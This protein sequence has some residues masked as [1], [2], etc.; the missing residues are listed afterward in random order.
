MVGFTVGD[1][2]SSPFLR[3]TSLLSRTS[4]PF[5]RTTATVLRE[6]G[7][8]RTGGRRLNLGG[9]GAG[10]VPSSS[11]GPES[12]QVLLLSLI[13]KCIFLCAILNDECKR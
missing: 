2:M 13:Y 1:V 4:S 3:T 5:L 12:S 8:A 10:N 9:A 7:P 11:S 6:G